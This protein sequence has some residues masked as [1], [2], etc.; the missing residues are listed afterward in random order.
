VSWER[1]EFGRETGRRPPF[2]YSLLHRVILSDTDYQQVL[3]YGRYMPILDFAQLEYRRHLDLLRP[4]MREFAMRAVAFDFSGPA[5][6]N[7]MIEVFV[8]A[9]RVGR[10]SVTF[11]FVVVRVDEETPLVTGTQTLVMMR[12]DPPHALPVPDEYRTIVEAFEGDDVESVR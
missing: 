9:Q 2:K 10:T 8:R 12:G 7:D 3:Y 4:G 6:V 11:D 5:R 1:Y